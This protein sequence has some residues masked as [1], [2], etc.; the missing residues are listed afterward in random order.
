MLGKRFDIQFLRGVA[1]LS[2]VLF[3]AFK[4]TFERGFLGVDIFF[5]I[6]GFLITGMIL[7]GLEQGRFSFGE[8]Y[9][10]RARRLLPASF[11][12]LAVTTALAVMLLT[13][14]DFA[15]YAKQLLGALTFSANFVLAQQTGYFAGEAESK[16]LLHIWSLSLEEQFY[17]VAP[18]LLWL[19]PLRARPWLLVSAIF[20]SAALCFTFVSGT[21]IPGLSSKG[22]AKFAFFMLPARAWELLIGSVAAWWMLKHPGTEVGSRVKFAALALIAYSCVFG[23]AP[24]HPGP[25]ALVVTLAT[26]IILLGSGRWLSANPATTAMAKLGDWSYSVY[27]VHWPLFAFAFI[28]FLGDPPA[29]ISIVLILLSLVLGFLQYAYV[30]QP[31]LSGRALPGRRLWLGL[32]GG[33]AAL[34]TSAATIAASSTPLQGMGP[35]VGLD[36]RCDQQGGAYANVAACR[37]GAEPKLVLWGDSYAMHLVTGMRGVMGTEWSFV[38]ATKS[39][40]SPVLGIAQTGGRYSQTWSR[41][42]LDF[43][44]SVVD[45]LTRMPSVRDVALAS[46]WVQVLDKSGRGVVVDG[47]IEPWSGAIVREHLVQTVRAVQAAGK[48]PILVGPTAMAPYNVGACNARLVTGRFFARLDG[49]DPSPADVG[50]RIGEVL[51]LLRSVA[52][53][54]GATL[55]LP[56][57]VMCP[58]VRCQ[59]L[60]EGKS[61]YR[62]SG[63]LTPYGSEYVMRALA[64]RAAIESPLAPVQH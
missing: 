3:H 12:T 47:H 35:Q 26:A 48:R 15:D 64:F 62:D 58:G 23:W 21:H 11:V 4:G 55:L 60:V 6:S 18:L 17:F 28:V 14:T 5:V 39:A 8:F 43:N 51:R 20:L 50:A 19:T 53:E 59:S 56:S 36:S 40:C 13:P 57:A 29:W 61:L 54:T 27:L 63:H 9:V 42:C 30:E 16:I 1:V 41:E 37:V 7:R 38:Q 31:F 34:A 25:D 49:C 24:A 10:R 46:S 33:A 2:V 44:R 45:A 22:A 32:C 52:D